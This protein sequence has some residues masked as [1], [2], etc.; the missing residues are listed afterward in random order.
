MKISIFI[1]PE[2]VKNKRE[3][4]YFFKSLSDGSNQKISIVFNGNTIEDAIN[5]ADFFQDIDIKF[6]KIIFEDVTFKEYVRFVDLQCDELEFLFVKFERGGALKNRKGKFGIDI[7]NLIFKPSQIENAFVIDIGNYANSQGFLETENVGRI[8]N[9]EFE[10][11]KEGKGQIYFIGI[12]SYTENADFKNKVLDN[13]SFQNCDLSNCYFLNAKVD[14]TEF[15]NCIFPEIRNHKS[16]NKLD[17]KTN[18][19]MLFFF[20]IS[21]PFVLIILNNNFYSFSQPIFFFIFVFF[22][23]F[24]ILLGLFALNGIMH[25]LEY[26]ISSIFKGNK[27]TALNKIENFHHHFGVK[28]EEIINELLNKFNKNSSLKE[29]EYLQ[30]SYFNLIELYRQLKANFDKSDFQT[31]GNFFYAQRYIEMI[32][33]TYKKSWTE[34]WILNIHYMINGF[35]ERFMRPLMLLIVTVIV[36]ALIPLQINKE[37]ISISGTPFFLLSGYDNNK[38]LFPVVI[39]MKHSEIIQVKNREMKGFYLDKKIENNDTTTF[40]VPKLKED[41]HTAF[42]YSLSHFNFPFLSENKQWFQEVSPVAIFLGWIERGLLWSFS[43]AFI[44]AVFHRIKR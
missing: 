41:W 38:S 16:V 22:V 30:R 33:T 9:I 18:P 4:E 10:N 5:F 20:V 36:F 7:G 31:A 35:G 14:N 39:D 42:Y 11:H 25:P 40:Y 32:S 8:R 27:E 37:Y 3:L 24:Y 28:D 13:V 15:R 21:V 44:L 2:W 1:C 43:G 12:N 6:E 29:R 34:S 19:L 26:I 23:P 17:S